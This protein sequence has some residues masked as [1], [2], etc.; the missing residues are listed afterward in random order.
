MAKGS[1]TFRLSDLMPYS[2]FYKLK[3][4]RSRGNRVQKAN[5]SK[6]KS[7]ISRTEPPKS[8]KI[9]DFSTNRFSHYITSEERA[10]EPLSRSPTHPKKSKKKPKKKLLSSPVLNSQPSHETPL[11]S[12]DDRFD[13]KFFTSSSDIFVTEPNHPLPPPILTK[14]RL[15]NGRKQSPKQGSRSPSATQ[16]IKLRIKSPKLVQKRLVKRKGL[17]DSFVV[18]KYSSDP[19]GDFRESMVD[20]IVEN[21]LFS[22]KELEELLSCYLLLNSSEYHDLIVEVFEKIWS[23]ITEII[24]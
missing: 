7:Q 12:L 24:V 13:A 23:D 6:D 21:N 14:R 18:V 4:M 19:K 9:Q 20:M 22:L 16:Q 11:H 3:N 2:W 17:T 15:I 1:N 10:A 5:N 8:P